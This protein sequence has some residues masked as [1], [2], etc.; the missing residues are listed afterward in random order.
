M[1]INYILPQFPAGRE[2]FAQN[3]IDALVNMGHQVEVF[4]YRKSTVTSPLNGVSVIT[5]EIQCIL[6]V[7]LNFKLFLS[8][9]LFCVQNYSGLKSFLKSLVYMVQSFSFV[10]RYKKHM[11]DVVHFFWGHYPSILIY[12][13]SKVDQS[14]TVTKTMFLGA[15]DLH[16]QWRGSISIAN[17]YADM[18]FTHAYKNKSKLIDFGIYEDKIT[19]I[20]RGVNIPKNERLRSSE[21]KNLIT[22]LS[23]G[24]LIKDKRHDLSISIAAELLK[25]DTDVI[26]K[27]AGQG[28]ER[29]KL[30]RHAQSLGI[31]PS[32]IEM[33]GHLDKV[34]LQN[35]YQQSDYLIALSQHKS[36]CLPNVVKEAM[37]NGC[38]PIVSNSFAIEELVNDGVNGFVF[39]MDHLDVTIMMQSI[40]NLQNDTPKRCIFE[41]A[42]ESWISAKFDTNQNMQKY[43]STWQTLMR[44]T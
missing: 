27:I 42:G 44:G 7:F 3:D 26:L 8:G 10:E 36:E 9:L 28:P 34:N 15:Y 20:Y 43:I 24:A 41:D 31:L 38:I 6:Y 37:S 21:N 23:A 22:L 29:D 5:S 4:S 40:M 16:E 19:V 1:K 30:L 39:D 18:V 25:N 33:L 2:A 13:L 12:F 32:K 35:T 11:P 17:K 14:N